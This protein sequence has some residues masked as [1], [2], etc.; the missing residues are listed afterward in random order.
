M[1]FAL[2]IAATLMAL[3]SIIFGSFEEGTPLP[4]RL[5]KVGGLLG[6]TALMA[7]VAGP[8]WAIATVIAIVASGLA[9]HAWWTRKHGISFFRPHPR[10]RYRALRGWQE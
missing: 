3:G 4:L 1:C 10:E 8:G 9:V 2:V 5:A 6:L 7:H